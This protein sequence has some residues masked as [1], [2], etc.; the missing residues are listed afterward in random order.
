MDVE[1]NAADSDTRRRL[2][3]AAGEVFANKGFEQT[4]VR[5]ICRKAKA[6]IAAINYHFGNKRELYAEVVGYC[7]IWAEERLPAATDESAENRLRGF[8]RQFLWR[9]LDPGRP[10]WHGRLLAREMS[11]PTEALEGL[12]RDEIRPQYEVLQG[13]IRE[14]AGDVPPRVI[15]KCAASIVGQ[16]LHYHFARP[17]LRLVSPVYGDLEKHVEELADHVTR[18]SLAGVL[19][20]ASRYRK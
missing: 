12:V 14:L 18:F 7:Q 19:A 2:L 13:I 10:S 8:V 11:E 1:E 15:A 17:V 9:L 20:I 16:M 3:D 6:N 5:E 4:T